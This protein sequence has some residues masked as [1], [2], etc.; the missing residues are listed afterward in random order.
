MRQL[1]ITYSI[2]TRD[3]DSL[4]RYL[5]DISRIPLLAQ[6]EEIVLA[7][8][9]KEGD[10]GALHKLVQANLRFVVSVAKQFQHQGM[11][12]SDLINEGNVGLIKA[13][14][15]FDH[16]KGFKFIS[17]AVWW[18]RQ[19]IMQAL[20]N[21]A[22]MIRVPAYKGGS[23]SKIAEAR[24]RFEQLHQRKP[25]NEELA[26]LS[27]VDLQVLEDLEYNR[28]HPTS[29]DVPVGD[30]GDMTLVDVMEDLNSKQP[31][32]DLQKEALSKEIELLLKI[33]PEREAQIVIG[34][35]GMYGQTRMNL[36]ELGEK[37]DLTRERVR[38]IKE[39]ALK[40]MRSASQ[41]KVLLGYLED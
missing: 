15:K 19:A 8:K 7:K 33:L 5:N 38:Q 30:D 23:Y 26:K 6:E 29:I 18:V 14:S 13:A 37:L 4:D 25:T 41:S 10:A 21:K 17:Y 1:R 35:Y 34:Y 3:T 16:S 24:N 39:R 2:T 22:R 36:E 11:T 20:L 32:V 9:I 27:G 12:L 40:R 31:D 28:T